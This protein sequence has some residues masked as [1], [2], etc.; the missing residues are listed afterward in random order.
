MKNLLVHISAETGH[1]PSYQSLFASLLEGTPSTGK[2]RGKLLWRITRAQKVFFCTIDNDYTGF[3]VAA[4]FRALQGKKTVGLFL[5]PLQCFRKE[6]PI[7][8]TLKRWI[9]KALLLLPGLRILSI[10]PHPLEPRLTEVSHDWIY[11]PQLWDLWLEGPPIL[12]DTELSRNVVRQ[13]AGRDITIF[14]GA[15]NK[16][17]GFDD[18][19]KAAIAASDKSLAVHAGRVQPEY[20]DQVEALKNAGMI[21]ENRHVTDDEILSLYKVADRAWCCYSPDYD[22]ASGVFGRAVQTGVE[23]IIRKGSVLE[24]MLNSFRV[25]TEKAETLKGPLKRKVLERSADEFLQRSLK[26][27]RDSLS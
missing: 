10:V 27:V 9:F 15:G 24:A 5:R 17:K 26:V 25:P 16:I 1:L 7:I 23:P 14:I 6:R 20:D 2:L 12:P 19:V 18:F 13:R 22:Q 3:F 4:I 21:V 11:D 8:Y